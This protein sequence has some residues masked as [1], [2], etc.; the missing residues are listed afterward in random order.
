MAGKLHKN[1]NSHNQ[2]HEEK[3]RHEHL[4]EE[5]FPLPTEVER[6]ALA[7]SLSEP[8]CLS[9]QGGWVGV[10]GGQEETSDGVEDDGGRIL[11]DEP[12][13]GGG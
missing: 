3:I 13:C 10:A 8:R 2:K 6:Q 5:H 7:S 11:A 4:S 1:H 9:F 12:W